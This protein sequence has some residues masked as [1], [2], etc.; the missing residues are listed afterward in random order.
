LVSRVSMD[1]P[2]VACERGKGRA[3]GA[4]MKGKLSSARTMVSLGLLL[5]AMVWPPPTAAQVSANAPQQAGAPNEAEAAANF[6][7]LD[8]I[9]LQIESDARREI[10]GD[11]YPSIFTGVDRL[12]RQYEIEADAGNREAQFKT[13]PAWPRAPARATTSTS[14]RSTFG[15]FQRCRCCGR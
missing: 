3:K 8:A 15:I 9:L 6:R 10:A 2:A 11:L 12:V 7:S 13:E 14:K 5:P 1:E 4:A